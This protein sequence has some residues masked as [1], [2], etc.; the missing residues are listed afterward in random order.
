MHGVFALFDVLCLMYLMCLINSMC[1]MY[2]MCLLC[3]MLGPSFPQ[4]GGL[5]EISKSGWVGYF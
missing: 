5:F 2:L 4:L 1:L 3:D